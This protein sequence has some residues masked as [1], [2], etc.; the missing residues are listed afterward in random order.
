ML[1][2]ETM[3]CQKGIWRHR[4]ICQKGKRSTNE[5]SLNGFR[6]PVLLPFDELVAAAPALEIRL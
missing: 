4:V 5:S 6:E 1:Q 3:A 2:E